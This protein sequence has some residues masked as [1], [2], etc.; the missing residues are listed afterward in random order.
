MMTWIAS[1]LH[2]LLWMPALERTFIPHLWFRIA[3]MLVSY[4]TFM[5][6]NNHTSPMSSLR[7]RNAI[8]A[9]LTYIYE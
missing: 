5:V 2:R 1:F 7:Q 8:N 9:N 3:E 4:A 6:L